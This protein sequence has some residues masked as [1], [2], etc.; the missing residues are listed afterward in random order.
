[1]RETTLCYIE[2][3]SSYLMLHRTKKKE[4]GSHEKWLGVGGKIES[5]ETPEQ[6]IVREVQEETGFSLVSYKLRAKIYFYSDTW[7]DELMYLYT[8]DDFTGNQIE[9]SEGH[10]EWVKKQEVCDLNIWEGDK[11][12][13][14][15]LASD[16]GYFEL[17]LRYKGHQL[18]DY[19]WLGEFFDVV[20]ETGTPTGEFVERSIAHRDGIRHRTSHIW[21]LKYVDNKLHVLLQ[22]RSECKDSH[23]GC[24]DISS[25]GH[26]HAG[27]GFEES[28]IRELKEE[29]GVDA[30][31]NDLIYVG[32][33][34]TYR[35]K[36]FHG[37]LFKD[38]QVSRVFILFCD[39]EK[40]DFNLQ[41]EEVESVMW[42][43]MDQCIKHV[44]EDDIPHCMRD[45]ELEMVK[46]KA[47]EIYEKM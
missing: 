31:E 18:E 34:N 16:D 42:M 19:K 23:P 1:M 20:D 25:A 21:L 3:D 13:L 46:K 28:A 7:E 37:A 9:C 47:E 8:A 30:V 39:F 27:C 11:L 41:K 40:E 24:Y 38:N 5:G 4:D 14:E 33:I 6:C 44:K 45:Y 43:D 35:E 12:F 10:L 22:K 15:R 36:E 29:L 26:I 17:E 2:K 32:L